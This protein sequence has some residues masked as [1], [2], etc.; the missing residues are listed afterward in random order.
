MIVL[1]SGISID[2]HTWW[3]YSEISIN[4]RTMVMYHIEVGLNI[5]DIRIN[6]MT[7]SHNSH[8]VRGIH[9]SLGI[10]IEHFSEILCYLSFCSVFFFQADMSLQ[11]RFYICAQV[12]SCIKFKRRLL[13]MSIMLLNRIHF[14]SVVLWYVTWLISWDWPQPMRVCV[15]HATFSNV[16]QRALE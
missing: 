11:A 6:M 3:Y 13:I 16:S 10:S 8:F 12:H 7:P 5:Q 1:Y 4:I 9:R 15:T 2:L 14:L